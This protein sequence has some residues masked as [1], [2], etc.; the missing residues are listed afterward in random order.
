MDGKQDGVLMESEIGRL[1]LQNKPVNILLALDSIEK[2]YASTI[3]KEVDTTFAHATNL[4]SEMEKFGLVSFSKVG[5]V[6]YVELTDHGNRVVGLLKN[7]ILT[8]DSGE[9]KDDDK[10]SAKISHIFSKLNIIFEQELKNK[11]KLDKTEFIRASQRIGP[12]KREI[13][14]IEQLIEDLKDIENKRKEPL[15]KEFEALKSRLDELI[16]AKKKLKHF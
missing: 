11:N 9:K 14:K 7:L 13:D 15:K 6:K 10:I 8:L 4:L 2:P 5:R 3:S 1:I 12:Y 16:E